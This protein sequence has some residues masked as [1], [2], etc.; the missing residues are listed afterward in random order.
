M[1][2]CTMNKKRILA[3]VMPEDHKK[4][5][6]WATQLGIPISQLIINAIKHY[7]VCKKENK[8]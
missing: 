1:Y 2:N 6:L 5:K 7:I 8:E 3:D 4:I